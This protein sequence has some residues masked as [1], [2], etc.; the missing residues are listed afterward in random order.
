MEN[1]KEVIRLLPKDIPQAWYNILPDLPDRLPT[2]KNPEKGPSKI[3]KMRDIYVNKCLEYDNNYK[4]R[5]VE[6]PDFIK[7][8]YIHTGRPTPLYRAWR[9]EK[10]LNTP[11]HIY[12]KFEGV[13]PTGSYKV[14]ST[15]AQTAWAK[16]EGYDRLLACSA[17]SQAAATCYAAKMFNMKAR[18]FVD[19]GSYNSRPSQ[20]LQYRQL[21]AEVV[22]T[23]S[24]TTEIGRKMLKENPNQLGS[25][26]SS[27]REMLETLE[28]EKPRH[29]VFVMGSYNTHNILFLTIMGLELK[30]QIEIMG[31]GDPDVIVDCAAAGGN[32][33]GICLPFVKQKLDKK[34]KT[35]FIACQPE[36]WACFQ[37]GK[38]EYTE[39]FIMN[40]LTKIYSLGWR[41]NPP[42][43]QAKGL[44]VPVGAVIPSYLR[45]KGIM[46]VRKYSEKETAKAALTF[47]R[48]EGYIPA[49]EA[50]YAIKGGI[51]EALKAKE[52]NR[53]RVIIIN[54]SGH[55]Y[56]STKEYEKYLKISE[57]QNV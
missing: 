48:A 37:D 34:I 39:S 40:P 54:I 10:L 55:G 32:W 26:F 38:Y 53:K 28:R 42:Q 27:G 22:R 56:Y 5:W 31:E 2:A 18:V 51:E 44:M 33:S 30:K 35:R 49:P 17:G 57:K 25:L 50:T 4:D 46:E 52:E 45:H 1:I 23:P 3:D 43:I 16:E 47:I 19:A 36:G 12:Y 7:Q 8:A 29:S 13:S 11:A 6:I 14:I 15:L 9:T 24:E 20:I 41:K 21:G